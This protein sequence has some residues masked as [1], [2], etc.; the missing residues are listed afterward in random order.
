MSVGVGLGVGLAVGIRVGLGVG[1]GDGFGVGSDVVWS[2][3]GAGVHASD[4]IPEQLRTS[5]RSHSQQP[6]LIH[7]DSVEKSLHPLKSDVVQHPSLKL[8]NCVHTTKKFN[9]TKNIIFS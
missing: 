4:G 3:V 7:V 2:G 1:L 9:A 5:K 6:P 8:N